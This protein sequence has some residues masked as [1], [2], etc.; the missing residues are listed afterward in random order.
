MARC[1]NFKKGD[2]TKKLNYGIYIND[3]NNIK[4]DFDDFENKTYILMNGN[5]A[6][7]IDYD[8]FINNID[9]YIYNLF[10]NDIFEYKLSSEQFFK[11]FKNVKIN[12]RK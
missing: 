2:K 12:W 11:Y 3:F 1:I 8:N 5:Y 10:L 6:G 7:F 4:L 9:D